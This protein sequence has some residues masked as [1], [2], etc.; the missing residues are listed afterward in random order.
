MKVQPKSENLP[1]K[2]AAGSIYV[3]QKIEI[4]LIRDSFM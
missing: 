3:L 1:H 2:Y 4:Y